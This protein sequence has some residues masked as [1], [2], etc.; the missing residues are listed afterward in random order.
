LA[1]ILL[2]QRPNSP[3]LSLAFFTAEIEA[4]CVIID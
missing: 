4:A 1:G 3:T 2:E